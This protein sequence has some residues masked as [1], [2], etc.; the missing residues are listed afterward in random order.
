MAQH[1][2]DD[3]LQEGPWDECMQAGP[4]DDQLQE[5]PWVL[6]SQQLPNHQQQQLPN[7]QQQQLANHQQQQLPNHQQQQLPNHQQLPIQQLLIQQLPI[8]QL[9]TTTPS[10]SHGGYGY[11]FVEEPPNKFICNICAKVLR[12]PYLTE[13]CGQHYCESC[14]KHWIHQSGARVCPHC[15][16]RYFVHILNKALKREINELKVHCINHEKGCK[17]KNELGNL[18]THLKD[19]GYVEVEC[20]NKCNQRPMRNELGNHL[21]SECLLREYMCTHCHRV[22]SYHAITG[23]CPPN[24]IYCPKHPGHYDSCP[25]LKLKCSK[26]GERNIKRKDMG[27]HKSH[28]PKEPVECRFKEAGCDVKPLRSEL[29]DHMTQNTQQHLMLMMEAFQKLKEECNNYKARLV[30]LESQ[31]P[32]ISHRYSHGYALQS[33]ESSAYTFWPWVYGL[34]VAETQFGTFTEF[35]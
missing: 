10:V 3:Q 6:P 24:E 22:D 16:K 31:L 19:C 27:E 2:W 20:S 25:E 4:W 12:D 23:D 7:H 34:R 15:R 9:P 30:Y 5:D 14:I 11:E 33:P 26:C 13:C 32:P 28:C 35:C 1:H 8:Q 18:E 29:D 17:W 21:Q